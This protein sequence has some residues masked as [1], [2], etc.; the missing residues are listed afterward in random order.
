MKTAVAAVAAAIALGSARATDYVTL[1]ASDAEYTSSFITN[2]L[3]EGCGWSN[4]LD[5]QPDLDY[6]VGKDAKGKAIVLRTPYDF[7]GA[8]TYL[9]PGRSLTLDGG[10]LM[11]RSL[12]DNIVKVNDLRVKTGTLSNSGNS[13]PGKFDG[14]IEV[15]KSLACQGGT[16]VF[17]DF[18]ATMVAPETAK[19]TYSSESMDSASDARWRTKQSRNYRY[20]GDCSAFKAVHTIN[21]NG[22]LYLGCADFAGSVN[23]DNIGYLSVSASDVAVRGTVT[24]RDGMLVVPAANQLAVQKLDFA[25]AE[26]SSYI[27]SGVNCYS[28][29][30]DD[31]TVPYAV[32]TV[33]VAGMPS[34]T[35]KR[36]A[37]TIDAGATLTVGDAEFDETLV[38]LAEGAVLNVTNALVCHTPVVLSLP[39]TLSAGSVLVAL[40]VG[41]GVLSVDDFSAERGGKYGCRF[42]VRTEGGLQKL[43]LVES[44]VHNVYDATTGYVVLTNGE[45]SG[46]SDGDSWTT[47]GWWSD[48]E[49]PHA[50]TN[51]YVA[52]TIRFRASKFQGASLTLGGS[53]HRVD[54]ISKGI[55]EVDDLRFL[56]VTTTFNMSG[57]GSRRRLGG[58]RWTL[59]NSFDRPVSFTVSGANAA[60]SVEANLY[61]D[62]NAAIRL[63]AADNAD[64]TPGEYAFIGDMT[65]F[66]GT[67]RVNADATVKLGDTGLA[68]TILVEG[69]NDLLTTVA[70]DGAVVS[71]GK[72]VT[73]TATSVEVPETNAL[74][75]VNGLSLGGA[76]AKS[77][78]G[79][80]A[81]GGVGTA[82]EGAALNV[83]AGGLK[84]L[85][86]TAVGAIPVTFAAGAQVVLDWTPDDP[87]VAAKGL[88]L[89]SSAFA[90]A[91]TLTFAFD[92]KG[93]KPEKVTVVK[94][95]VTVSDA[96]AAKLDGKI[97]IASVKGFSATLL[98]ATSAGGF[99]TYSAEF[100]PK[101]VV[102]IFR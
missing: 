85:S 12:N 79:T 44:L 21:W 7:D 92:L 99:T 26:P 100:A 37:V 83:N 73:Q 93:L 72:L 14:R 65:N 87:A 2:N 1:L 32:R 42:E 34:K 56:D 74:A 82:G 96:D 76:L 5:P 31:G 9:F 86:A 60:Y 22:K 43:C 49:A 27:K 35:F 66:R 90:V 23:L 45:T 39:D 4:H 64:G 40:P 95:L 10:T 15:T 11:S 68:G 63:T 41:K 46:S 48:G 78:A 61:G 24:G 102:L 57:N 69:A 51:Y 97:S 18:L 84:P 75:V 77:G 54:S 98:P 33:T 28:M 8:E 3:T 55:A 71:V 70:T 62:E 50:T 16:G 53:S 81:V 20:S 94:P 25:Y 17:I 38:E 80:L 58:A 91:D 29:L 67:C 30:P 52:K 47:A 19:I 89:S 101:G 6:S 59:L 88:D 13:T 36:N